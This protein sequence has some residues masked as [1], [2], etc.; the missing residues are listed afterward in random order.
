MQGKLIVFEGVE[1]GGKTTQ[2]QRIQVWLQT[3]TNAPVVMTREPG[4]TLF[5][6]ELRRLLLEYQGEEPLQDRAELLM[7]AADRAQHIE[8]FLKPLLDQGTIILCDRYTD[9]TIAYQGYGRGLDLSLIDQLNQIATNGLESDLTLWLD[10]DVELGLA[11]TRAR[12]KLDRMEQATLEFHQRVQQGFKRL[13]ET[14][15]ER[16][17]PINGRLNVDEVTEKI[18]FILK[19]KLIEWGLIID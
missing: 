16:I 3:L 11:R 4:G 12:G 10:V 17:I 7:Y 9:S 5:G 1:G 14:Y 19:N 13:A 8:G 18:Q 6:Q 2:M 15:P